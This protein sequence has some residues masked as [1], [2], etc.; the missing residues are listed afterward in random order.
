MDTGASFHTTAICEVL[1]NYVAG[2]FG[3]VY[4]ADG[5]PLDIVGIGDVHIKVHSD[6]VWKLQKVKHV[7]QLK[8]NLISMGQLDDEGHTI[9]FHGGQWKICMGARLLARGYKTGTLY[10]TT[11][12]R[13]TVAVAKD[14]SKLWHLRLGHMSEKEMKVLLSK[15]KLPKLK[16]VEFDLCEDCILGK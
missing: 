1:E 3:K 15:G 8:K 16:S 2:D 11:N 10:L 14:D 4:L 5:T 6:S 12:P 13:D 9:K 7:P